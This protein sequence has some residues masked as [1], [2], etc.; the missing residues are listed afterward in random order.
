MDTNPR[1]ASVMSKRYAGLL[2]AMHLLGTSLAASEQGVRCAQTWWDQGVIHVIRA[3]FGALAT[4][5]ILAGGTVAA[6]PP[7][8]RCVAVLHL[9]RGEG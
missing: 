6:A 9:R 3:V 8:V 1:V 7:S 4:A 2:P 5:G